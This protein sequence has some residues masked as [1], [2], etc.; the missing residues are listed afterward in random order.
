MAWQ[1]Y[2]DLKNARFYC[3]ITE[4]VMVDPVVDPEGNSYRE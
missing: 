1:M 2:S 3:P 4:Q